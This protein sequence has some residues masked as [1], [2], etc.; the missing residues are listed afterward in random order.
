MFWTRP[1]DETWMN[2]SPMTTGIIMTMAITT[3]V[4]VA[5]ITIHGSTNTG[6]SPK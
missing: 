3:M 4:T 2:F 1:P 5:T 6:A